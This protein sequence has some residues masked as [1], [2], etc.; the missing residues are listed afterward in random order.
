LAEH[1]N[2]TLALERYA[3]AYRRMGLADP[4][5]VYEPVA[6]AYYYAQRLR[7]DAL[8]LVCDFGG[9]TSDFS[10]IRFE[11]RDNLVAATPL[12]HAGLASPGWHRRRQF[13]LPEN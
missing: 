3:E 8:V 1:P 11:C 13:R 6:A 7:S 5:Y 2:E 4:A 10:L 9:G 12:G